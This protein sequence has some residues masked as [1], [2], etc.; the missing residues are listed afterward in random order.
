[1]R[2]LRVAVNNNGL[3]LVSEDDDSTTE[4]RDV[5]VQNGFEASYAYCVGV[6][7]VGSVH[8]YGCLDVA[9]FPCRASGIHLLTILCCCRQKLTM[10]AA[11]QEQEDN[12]KKLSWGGKLS[13]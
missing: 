3:L 4:S 13:R 8:S 11:A 7:S 2:N 6:L 5:P 1:M 12:T 9:L 10:A